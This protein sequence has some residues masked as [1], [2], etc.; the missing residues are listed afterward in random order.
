MICDFCS[1]P[2]PQVKYPVRKGTAWAACRACAALI[3][4]NDRF[5]L[6]RRVL[7][8]L[9]VTPKFRNASA[10]LIGAMVSELA[11]HVGELFWSQRAGPAQPLYGPE[12][13][14]TELLRG[15]G[16]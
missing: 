16:P 15:F 8:R 7:E 9:V 12:S 1:D 14:D 2:D 3:D 6:V 11:A 13:I 4:K 10:I 5:G